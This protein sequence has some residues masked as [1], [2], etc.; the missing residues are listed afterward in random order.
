MTQDVKKRANSVATFTLVDG[1]LTWDYGQ[2]IGRVVVDSSKGSAAARAFLFGYG[3]K[4]WL[5]DGAAVSAGDDGKVDPRAKFEGM[6]ERAE[7][8]LSGADALTMRR[9]KSEDASG[10]VLLEGMMRGLG[11]DA[12]GLEALLVATMAKKGVDRKGALEMWAKTDKVIAGVNAVKAERAAKRATTKAEDL[13]AEMM[14]GLDD[15]PEGGGPAGE[16][17]PF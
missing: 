6:L 9:G 1:V 17:A 3:L 7:L 4:Q 8:F 10:T 13:E 16:E 5:Q 14:A 2:A 15:T 11:R 12:A